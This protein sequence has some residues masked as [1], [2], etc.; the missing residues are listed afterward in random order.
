MGAL[1]DG[2]SPQSQHVG[3]HWHI[4]R[5][6]RQL[7]WRRTDQPDGL[8]EAAG[9]KSLCVGDV[10]PLGKDI[11]HSVTNPIPKFS[12]AIHVYG[13]DF[14]NA[15]HR[16]EWDAEQLKEKDYNSEN[17]MNLFETFPTNS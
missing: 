2:F 1:D 8:I 17:V 5:Q 12:G 7:F 13:G 16:S 15:P 3:S 10:T 11:I 6:G 4:L 9:A 14:F